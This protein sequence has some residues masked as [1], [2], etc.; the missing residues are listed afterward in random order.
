M[1]DIDL[2]ELAKFAD[3]LSQEARDALRLYGDAQVETR[4]A[5]RKALDPFGLGDGPIDWAL[6]KLRDLLTDREPEYRPLRECIVGRS[7]RPPSWGRGR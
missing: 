1:A 7:Y 6:D 2:N 4:L 3:Q 5:L